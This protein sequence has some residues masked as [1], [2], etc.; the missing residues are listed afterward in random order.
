VRKRI[1]LH[2]GFHKTGSSSLQELLRANRGRLP[3]DCGCLVQRDR[4]LDGLAA[5]CKA[6]DRWPGA[7]R[8]SWV[9]AEWGEL[10]D[11]FLSGPRSTLILSNEDFLGRIPSARDDT[12]LY[13]RS[14][15][16]LSALL[17]PADG[18]EIEPCVYVRSGEAW[19]RSLYGHLL[20]TRG[21]RM[22]FAAFAA[23]EK[24]RSPDLGAVAARLGGGAGRPMTVL[25][26]E[27]DLKTRLGPGTAF[28]RRCGL[29]DDRLAD[30]RP[31]GRRNEGIPETVV[32]RM[33]SSG[34]LMLP[35]HL[36]KI[37]V[38]RLMAKGG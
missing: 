9:A 2:L 27:D 14:A 3:A 19:R 12:E 37:V 15:D 34:M 31:V 26:F 8:L 7:R 23:V 21:I 17:G 22:S 10:V 30:W 18:I 5:A 13:E 4:E 29:G 28:L 11:R 33:S 25:S 20:K 24:F 35:R 6:Y 16:L 32:E 38:G 1:V 36:R